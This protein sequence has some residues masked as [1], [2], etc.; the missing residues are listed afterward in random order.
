MA[1]E[2][3]ICNQALGFLGGNRIIS[4]D[5]GTTEANLCKDLYA[6]LRDVVL[7]EH[8]WTFATQWIEL[9]ALATTPTGVYGKAYELPSNVLRVVEVT[10][11][12]DWQVEDR[13]IVT[14]EAAV[15]ARCIMRVTDPA[16]FSPGFVQAMAARLAADLALPLTNSRSMMEAMFSLYDAKVGRAVTSDNRQGKARRVRSKWLLNARNGASSKVAGP[17]V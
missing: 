5:D 1:T 11:N 12:N 2:V 10:D 6:N 13:K 4:L 8:N 16:K 9:P 17:T 7:E 14:N 3:S 15:K